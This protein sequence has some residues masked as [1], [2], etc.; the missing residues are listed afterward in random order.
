MRKTIILIIAFAL[1]VAACGGGDDAASS[2]E[3]IADEAIDLIQEAIDEIDAMD[4][5]ELMAMEEDPEVFTTMEQRAEELQE[6]ATEI[7]CSDAE[8]EELFNARVGDL[9]ADGL[10][11]EFLV[12]EMQGGGFFE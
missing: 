2:C 12:E 6:N 10:F 4:V 7:G 9:K 5:D 8:M 11:G 1:A 3:G